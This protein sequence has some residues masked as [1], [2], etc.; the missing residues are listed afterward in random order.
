VVHHR[1]F[2]FAE[3]SQLGYFRSF[4]SSEVRVLPVTTE[5]RMQ[6]PD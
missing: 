4:R 3:T 5:R 1:A 6:L 2:K